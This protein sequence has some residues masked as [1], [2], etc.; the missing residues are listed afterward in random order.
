MGQ[1]FETYPLE[2]T[3]IVDFYK[4]NLIG[5]KDGKLVVVTPQTGETMPL[6]LPFQAEL[7]DK[8]FVSQNYIFCVKDKLFMAY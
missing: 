6:N 5:R 4:G 2:N 8:I 1:L 7:S 3:T